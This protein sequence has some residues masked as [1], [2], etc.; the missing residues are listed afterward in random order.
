MGV[1]M[2]KNLQ[3]LAPVLKGAGRVR[4]ITRAGVSA[5][6]PTAGNAH[7]H[8]N[9]WL[10][11]GTPPGPENQTYEVVLSGFRLEPVDIES[12][13][14]RLKMLDTTTGNQSVELIYPSN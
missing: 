12:L 8:I 3:K 4:F 6:G 13:R 1:H 14:P 5:G 11:C 2:E 10:A 7:V 9:L